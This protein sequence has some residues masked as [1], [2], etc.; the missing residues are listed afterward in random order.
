MTPLRRELAAS[1][2]RAGKPRQSKLT[3]RSPFDRA[4]AHRLEWTSLVR[5]GRTAENPQPLTQYKDD[6]EGFCRDILGITLWAKQIEIMEAIRDNPRVSV[7]ACY[8]SGKT[9]TAACLGIWWIYTRRPAMLVTTAPTGR[10]VKT[11]LWR[12]IRKLIRRAKRRLPGRCLQ[13]ELHLSEDWW[14]IGFSS[15]GQ[16]TVAGLHEE[17]VLF[18]EDEAAGMS[19]D[20]CEGFEGITAGDDAKH[21]KIGNPICD[22]GP[23]L[24]SHLHPIESQRW[25]KI[26]ID[27]EDTPNVIARRKIVPGLV[28]FKWVEDKRTRWKARGL[29]HLW[30]TKVKG[31]FFTRKTRS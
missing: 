30:E 3:Y 6:P 9:F 18:I 1:R 21:L 28:E 22:S 15:D 5:Y 10:Q 11:L 13:T 8:A 26:H 31:N 25:I 27:A 7:A 4:L 24:D 19:A 17:N 20:V 29:L 2:L 16:N 14:G 23:F 12:E